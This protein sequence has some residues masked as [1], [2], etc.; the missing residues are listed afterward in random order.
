M[1]ES[2]VRR[3]GT[4]PSSYLPWL[5]V[6]IISSSGQSVEVM[7][8][9]S[10]QTCR[11]SPLAVHGCFPLRNL[12]SWITPSRRSSLG[13]NKVPNR[14]TTSNFG[15]HCNRLVALSE[16]TRIVKCSGYRWEGLV[17]H[18]YYPLPRLQKHVIQTVQQ[19][20]MDVFCCSVPFRP[21]PIRFHRAAVT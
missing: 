14:G 1:R 12:P 8:H 20:G 21:Q 11:W 9:N 17:S 5:P 4:R 13:R 6:M 18:S 7:H 2:A 3:A 16:A 15:P 19:R 10:C